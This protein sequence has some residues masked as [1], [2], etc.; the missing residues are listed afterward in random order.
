MQGSLPVRYLGDIPLACS[1]SR[2]GARVAGLLW[3]TAQVC[4]N[5]ASC[6]LGGDGV[7]CADVVGHRHHDRPGK[8]EDAPEPY[9]AARYHRLK[10]SPTS[11]TCCNGEC[12]RLC[13]RLKVR[14]GCPSWIQ[15]LSFAGYPLQTVTPSQTSKIHDLGENQ[16]V[17]PKTDVTVPKSPNQLNSFACYGVTDE[18][19]LPGAGRGV[20]DSYNPA[21]MHVTT[22]LPPKYEAM[23]AERGGK[24]SGVNLLLGS[25]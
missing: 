5:A 3:Q 24:D 11:T 10:N 25:D 4:W 23:L 9:V 1:E 20:T 15:S 13:P 18:N 7:D 14:F 6:M 21:R 17:T 2:V 19:P 16:A 12:N 22:V 8:N